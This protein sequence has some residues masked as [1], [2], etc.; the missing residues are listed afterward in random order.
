MAKLTALA[1]RMIARQLIA[2][3]KRED[4]T[5]VLFSFKNLVKSLGG[6]PTHGG[7]GAGG[8]S[9]SDKDLDGGSA[10]SGEDVVD[11]NDVI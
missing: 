10:Q 2:D 5:D 11:G 6:K 9:K 4:T 7:G 3:L 1:T 8:N